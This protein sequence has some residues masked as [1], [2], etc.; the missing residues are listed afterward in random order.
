MK[1]FIFLCVVLELVFSVERQFINKLP[2]ISEDFYDT[3]TTIII[4]DSKLGWASAFRELIS[5]LYSGSVS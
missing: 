3:K 1:F 5:L 2:E 4:K